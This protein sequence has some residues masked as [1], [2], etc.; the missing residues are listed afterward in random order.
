M[1]YR[2]KRLEK[3]GPHGSFC[4]PNMMPQGGY[5]GIGSKV[6]TTIIEKLV[7]V[8]ISNEKLIKHGD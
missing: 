2:K 6:N 1:D 8:G 7:S 5:K 3:G 4:D